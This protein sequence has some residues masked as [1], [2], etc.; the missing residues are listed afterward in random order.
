MKERKST[1]TEDQLMRML[2][3]ATHG[4]PSETKSEKIVYT[5]MTIATDILLL[6]PLILLISWLLVGWGII[7][8][9]AAIAFIIGMAMFSI[10]MFVWIKLHEKRYSEDDEK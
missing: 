2:D 9:V 6:A 1:K 10:T 5:I 8:I 4:K 7:S 3:E